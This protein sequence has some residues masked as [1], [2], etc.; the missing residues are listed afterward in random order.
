MNPPRLA[1]TVA[2]LLVIGAASVHAADEAAERLFAVQVKPLLAER[3]FVCHGQDQNAILGGLD[4]TS[5]D[6]MLR[7]GASSRPALTPGNAGASLLY[8]A[9]LRKDPRLQMPPKD[10]DRLTQEQVWQIR[11]WID[12]GAPWPDA[13]EERRYVQDD[14]ADARTAAGVIVPPSGGLSDDWTNRRYQEDDLWAFRPLSRAEPPVTGAEHPVDAF[15]ERKL[16]DA[17]LAPASRADKRMLIRRASFDLTGLPPTPEQ[18]EA[19]LR[20]DSAAAWRKVVDRLLESPQ[21]GEQW[22]RH[23]LDVVRY[24]DT[25]GYSNDWERS[26]AWRYRDYVVR[27]LNSD[28]PYDRFVL[29]QL[30][31]D[32]LDPDSPEMRVATG[33]LRMGPWEHTGMMQKVASRQ[34][35]LDDITNSVGESFLSLPLRCAKCHDHKF[36]PIPT[37]DYYRIYAVFETTQLAELPVEFIESENRNYFEQERARLER[38]LAEAEAD[39]A[40]IEAKE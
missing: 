4:L 29:E 11:D 16:V 36:D 33:Y 10:S 39:V 9:V 21:Y 19:F 6:A 35:Y 24:A 34:L 12:A 7:G 25:S 14:L 23:W 8:S 32:I 40:K 28:K 15:I 38:L 13:E 37:R 5:R 22:G 31:G 17:G 26:N 3:C 1:S 30:A 27:S 18:V 2:A 20:D